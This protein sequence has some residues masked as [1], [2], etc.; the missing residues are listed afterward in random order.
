MDYEVIAIIR[1][2]D[3][4]KARIR[5]LSGSGWES[6][7]IPHPV[8]MDLNPGDRLLISVNKL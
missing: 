2:K 7:Q 5:P 4:T 8:D 6:F 1:D 3:G